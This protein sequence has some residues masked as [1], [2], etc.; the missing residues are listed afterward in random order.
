LPG[1]TFPTLDSLFG[2]LNSTFGGFKGD[3]IVVGDIDTGYNSLSPSFQATDASGY[4]ITNPL[5]S[6]NYLGDCGV[7]GISLG[8]CNDKVIGVYDE[9]NVQYYNAAPSSVEDTQG[10]GSHTAS[11]IAGDG[12]EGGFPGFDA[13]LAGI[14]PHANLVIYYACAPD[15]VQCQDS[16][17]AG[18]VD[19]AIQDGVVDV[20]NY[21]I[22]GGNRPWNDP[23][24]QAFLAAEDSGIFVAAAAGNTGTDVP[25]AVPGTVNHLEPWVATVAATTLPAYVAE[26][27]LSLTGPGTPPAAATDVQLTEG[28]FDTAPDAAFAPTT[29]IVLSP[30]F[31]A[32]DTNGTDGCNSAGG[33][34][35]GT[36]NNA[37]ALISRGTCAFAEKVPNAIAAGAIAVIISD[38]RIEGPFSPTVG[39]PQV[40]VPVYSIPQAGGIAMQSY[41]A[42]KGGSGTASLG[43]GSSRLPLKA[44]VLADFSL[45][46]PGD[47]DVIKPDVAA[48]GVAVLAAVANDGSSNGP[49]LVAFYDG[50]SM[51]TPHITGTGALVLGM[52]PDWTPMEV[53][54]AIMMTAQ[55][56]VTKPDG[57]TAADLYDVG[58]GRVQAFEAARAGLVLDETTDNMLAAYPDGGGDPSTLNLASMQNSNCAAKCTFTRTFS[59]TQA[60]NW[61]VTVTGELAGSVTVTPSTF[62][63]AKGATLALKVAVDSSALEPLSGMHTATVEISTIT[64]FPAPATQAGLYRLPLAVAVP[65]PSIVAAANSV[66]IA[67][68]SSGSGS[69]TLALSN[70]GFG[71]MGFTPKNSGSQPFVW[72]NQVTG[73]YYGEPS[74]HYTT[75]VQAGDFDYYSAD[76]FTI[77]GNAPVD[78]STIVTPGF[79]SNHT[80]SSFG[81]S[82][83]VHWR[84]YADNNGQPSSDP[85]TNGPA[86]WSYDSTAGGAGVSVA[87]DTISLDLVAAQ[88]STALPAGHYWLVAYP[89]MPC[90]DTQ[91]S[92]CNEGWYWLNSWAGSGA[93][94]AL[95]SPGFDWYNGVQ[96]EPYGE[97]LAMSITS[98]ANCALRDWLSLSP[99]NGTVASAS[100]STLTFNADFSTSSTPPPQTTYVCLATSYLDPVEGLTIPKGVVPIQVNAQ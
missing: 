76:D 85:I 48:P 74:V 47:F 32:T 6:G 13:N 34:P 97:G 46:G 27:A 9:V 87:R 100:S 24:S 50:T 57:Q 91:G 58:S 66:D 98:T 78:L 68:D 41:L 8:G 44:D 49:N 79:S 90:N 37:I 20:L 45:I 4:T 83:G 7:D 43:Y 23:V 62:S 81:A 61:T 73:N 10:H 12:R 60:G 65:P 5:G 94:W 70:P 18:S 1:Y 19:Q 53:K 71:P 22:S 59:A 55:G 80:L 96:N 82:L 33:Y 40:S 31:R 63:L 26:L 29:P 56:A 69:A 42:S 92:G 75:G 86:V 95:T 67:L 38:N 3:G 64:E 35:A 16:A 99:L 15:P 36:F 2:E 93:T 89:D 28:T 11:T 54:S 88:Q 25:V 52:H 77:T 72:I 51:A 17:T 21:S 30:Q 14:A 84:I 39:P